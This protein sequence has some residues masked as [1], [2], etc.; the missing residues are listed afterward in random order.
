MRLVDAI[1]YLA[2]SLTTIAFVPQVVQTWRSRNTA[3]ISLGMICLFSLGVAMWLAYGC[4][5]GA[6]PVMIANAITLTLALL[7][8]AMKLRWR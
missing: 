7:L 2:A 6:W 8:L 3:A 5:I 1:G 4:L